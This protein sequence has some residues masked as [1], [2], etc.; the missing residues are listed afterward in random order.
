MEGWQ[1]TDVPAYDGGDLLKTLYNCG[2]GLA[3]DDAGETPEDT[4]MQVVRDTDEAAFCAYCRK[5][6][7][8]GFACLFTRDE[9]NGLYRQY[10]KDALLVYVY[11]IY[12]ERTA[13]ILLDRCCLPLPAFADA[14]LAEKHADTQLMQ[15]GLV[16]DDMIHGIGCDCGMNYVLRLR[17]GR[18]IVID[19]GEFEQATEASVGEFMRR[20][21]DMTGTNE[22][23]P[24]RIALW[25]CTH[26]HNDHM[27]F[28]TKLLRKFGE[29]IRL[30][31]VLFNFASHTVLGLNDYVQDMRRAV[32][33]HS[34]DVLF[35]KAHTGQRF[36]VGNAQIDVLFTHEDLLARKTGTRDYDSANTTSTIMKIS[37][38]DV[39]LLLLAD[40]DDD[41][42][43]ELC[44]RF[45]GG[46]DCTF[47]QAAHHLINRVECIYAN[48]RAKYVLIPE[49]LYLIQKNLRGNY[50]VLCKY[51]DRDNF[52]F[53]GNC[54]CVFRVCGDRI[55]TAYYPVRGGLYDGT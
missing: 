14:L 39:S 49:G 16:Y 27:D 33:R 31:R 17:D 3:P 26:P 51:Y 13:R 2:S 35:L 38:E 46:V 6:G 50:G 25:Y 21:R 55:E 1:L 45:P 23:D 18:L 44:A 19:G 41:M 28:F 4:K 52:Y 40:A 10:G 20:I 54:T 30:E 12:A 15:F 24:V 53:A 11:Y 48:V 32:L 37:F 8:A 22:G 42:G 29:M 7:D 5:L 47:I 36:F 9:P 34:P 43:D